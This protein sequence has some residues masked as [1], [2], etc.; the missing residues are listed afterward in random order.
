MCHFEIFQMSCIIIPQCSYT[1]RILNP[2]RGCSIHAI[3]A[4]F[5]MAGSILSSP[6]AYFR[7]FWPY[8][9]VNRVGKA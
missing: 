1:L 3:A 4:R 6:G 2:Y 7:V 9:R 8:F 5:D